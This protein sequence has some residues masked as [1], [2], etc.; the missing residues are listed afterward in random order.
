MYSKYKLIHVCS[1]HFFEFFL[2]AFFNHLN[3]KIS[4]VHCFLRNIGDDFLEN[5]FPA[6][7]YQLFEQI[8]IR[9]WSWAKWSIVH[10]KM[11]LEEEFKRQILYS[12]STNTRNK[13]VHFSTWSNWLRFP[14]LLTWFRFSFLEIYQTMSGFYDSFSTI[15]HAI[16]IQIHWDQWGSSILC[17]QKNYSNA[18]VG[19][20][21]SSL[22]LPPIHRTNY[23]TVKSEASQVFFELQYFENCYFYQ[24]LQS[25]LLYVLLFIFFDLKL[26]F[27]F[28][29]LRVWSLLLCSFVYNS[30][31][32]TLYIIQ[33][34]RTVL[35]SVDGIH[36]HTHKHART[37]AYHVH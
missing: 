22:G 33:Y 27:F 29:T 16:H 11:S 18:N 30:V 6:F 19:P 36:K 26:L 31:Q 35:H 12:R 15:S 1:L 3:E 13:N 34:I 25:V 20:A 10:L 21:K 37:H 32:C 23:L 24:F 5:L 9:L 8:A 14:F 2:S 17:W 4:F 7:I 28:W